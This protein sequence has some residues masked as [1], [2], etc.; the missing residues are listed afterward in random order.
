MP[1]DY[2]TAVLREERKLARA[3][4]KALAVAKRAAKA[5]MTAQKKIAGGRVRK[6]K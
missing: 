1:V 2:K 6:L 3:A 4:K 5:A